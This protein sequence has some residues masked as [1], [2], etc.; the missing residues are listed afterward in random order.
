MGSGCDQYG[1]PM[2]ILI[3]LA[4]AIPVLFFVF[5]AWAAS[6]EN[7]V[8]WNWLPVATGAGFIAW[9]LYWRGRGRG[10]RE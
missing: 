7:D 3:S 2:R 10:P 6:A 9:V 8:S 4:I 1:R 5:M